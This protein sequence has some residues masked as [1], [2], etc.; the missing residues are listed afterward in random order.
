MKRGALIVLAMA[1]LVSIGYGWAEWYGLKVVP[2]LHGRIVSAV[3]ANDSR[4]VP[5]LNIG[6]AFIGLPNLE[7]SLWVHDRQGRCAGD[8]ITTF[9][10]Q[11]FS[12]ERNCLQWRKH[13]R[14]RVVA[15]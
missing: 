12:E 15:N 9:G 11:I 10:L 1:V 6:I 3:A 4:T 13:R 5:L 14:A 2:N 7:G 8:Y